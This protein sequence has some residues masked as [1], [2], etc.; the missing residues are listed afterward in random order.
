MNLKRRLLNAVLAVRIQRAFGKLGRS[1]A[2]R[3]MRVATRLRPQ[4][5]KNGNVTLVM[6]MIEQNHPFFQWAMG[7]KQDLHP[8]VFSR[9]IG[10]IIFSSFMADRGQGDY[11]K[12]YGTPPLSNLLFSVTERCNLK[13]DGCWAAEYDKSEDLSIALMDRVIREL[14][15]MRANIVTL[16][17]GEP[18]LRADVFDL[19]RMHPD[20]YFQVFTNGTLISEN[21]ADRIREAANVAPLISLNGFEEANDATRGRGNFVA[22]ESAFNILK[23]RGVLFGVSLTATSRN[24]D[25]LMDP[26]FYDFLIAKGAKIGWVFQYMPVGR[27]PNLDLMVPPEKRRE[28]GQFIYKLRNS[29]PFF[30]VDFWNDGPVVGGCM[31]GARH[32]LHITNT[33]DVEPCVFCHFAVDNIK[34]KSLHEVIR[35]PFF[36]DIKTAI[37]YDGN[38]LRPCM[39]VDRPEVFRSHYLRHLPHPTHPGAES[40]VTELSTGLDERAKAMR[41]I[42]DRVW[43]EKEFA[44]LYTFDPRWYNALPSPDAQHRAQPR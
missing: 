4:W 13:C 10:N 25:T 38:V 12:K 3:L 31:A 42:M 22:V 2:L 30:I 35:S 19:F 5:A 9:F 11:E 15:E 1:Q 26:A 29:R 28:L 43:N 21:V 18:F 7:L 34:D 6:G 36:M 44:G 24:V 20:V 14:K 8:R 40:L 33:G 37:P 17:G 39:M 41:P 32:Y 16:T 27:A 23:D